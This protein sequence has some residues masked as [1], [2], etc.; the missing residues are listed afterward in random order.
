M[1]T[2]IEA[3]AQAL[4]HEAL[5]AAAGPQRALTPVALRGLLVGVDP[6]VVAE[7]VSRVMAEGVALPPAAV[8]AFGLHGGSGAPA[9]PEPPAIAEPP[10]HTQ[11]ERRVP[12]EPKP[13]SRRS[14]HFALELS[15]D[16]RLDLSALTVG[17]LGTGVFSAPQPPLRAEKPHETPADP[18]TVPPAQPPPNPRPEPGADAPQEDASPRQAA[19][20]SLKH[21][22]KEI[23]R[24]P[25]L[26]RQQE[27]ELAQAIEAG[28]LAREQLDEAGRKI[29][30]KL[31][32]ELEQ[33]VRLGELAFTDFA[34]ANLRLVV[35]MAT[36]YTGR[37]L[38]LM[39]LIQEGN[40]GM[41]H[42]IEKFDHRKGFKFSTY[43]VQWIR[44]AIQRAIADQSRTVRLPVYAHDILIA[45]HKAARELGHDAPADALPAVAAHAEV[46]LDK[47][48]EL[49]SHVRRTLPL[50]DLTEA[51]GDDA[52][53]EEADPS[54]HGTHWSESDAYYKNLSPK[55]VHYILGCLSERE[56]RL[57]TLRH[58]LDG[59]PELTLE[60]TGR[61][62]GVT[63]ERVRQVESKAMS[64][65][66]GRTLEYL[67]PPV[68][69]PPPL[70]VEPCTTVS[71]D[72]PLDLAD[73]LHVTR[74]VHH[75]GRIL[76]DRQTID[77]GVQ[78]RG[79][80]VTVLLEDDWFR[81][82]F[83]GR[84]IAASPRRHLPRSRRT[85]GICD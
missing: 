46:Q 71:A 67:H 24:F 21:Y 3:G 18:A 15:Q 50:E 43:A 7:V 13:E 59:G 78:Y 77:V 80:T 51:I 41:I 66:R 34:H 37:G 30:P 56:R 33:L 68:V 54:V 12:A 84:P 32:R 85:Y 64:K 19:F 69:T 28:L 53:H 52:L 65:L 4:L 26:S 40:V 20:D 81:V 73:E 17:A 9:T 39:D 25:L 82:L 23:G 38:D 16:S 62:L 58:G 1:T 10:S 8:A 31:R 35:S 45:L 48:A 61:I 72:P 42:A 2:D 5:V 75:T 74:K 70:H 55:E 27:A 44:Q 60:A 14:P 22:R 36:W 79:K 29:A 47:A 57:I 63:R 11:G 76:V 49:L 83:E 6:A